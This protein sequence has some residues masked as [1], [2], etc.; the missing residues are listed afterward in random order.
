MAT[1]LYSLSIL[2]KSKEDGPSSVRL[3][4]TLMTA[5]N[6]SAQAGLMD[7]LRTAITGIIT[8][9]PSTERRLAADTKLSSV[10]P[11]DVNAQRE[12]KWLV[13]YEDDVTHDVYRAEI[14]TADLALLDGPS[15]HIN[16][17]TTGAIA[18]F[19]AAFEAVVLS[20]AG[21]AVT[22]LDIMFVGKRL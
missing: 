10:R 7:T 19:V 8:G 16:D 22:I 21:N 15:D 18:T 14:P 12:I 17:L 11:T 13:T 5:G 4:T 2:D 20:K 3:H 1:S 9:T 6:F